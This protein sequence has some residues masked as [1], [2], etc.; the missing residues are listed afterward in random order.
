LATPPTLAYDGERVKLLDQSKLPG[1]VRFV[2]ITT[3][4]S[5]AHAIKT[6]QV[7]GAPAIGAA[8]AFGMVL[9]AKAAKASTTTQLLASLAQAKALLASTRPTAVN[10]FWALDEMLKQV[11]ES[12]SVR[13][14]LLRL[15]ARAVMLLQEDIEIN[16]RLGRNGAALFEEPAVIYT[17]CNAGALATCGYG[18][19]LGVV[20]AL[21]EQGKLVRVY[22]DETRP[23]LQGARLTA[24]ELLQDGIPCT[25]VCDTMAAHVMATR[26]V[27][28]VVVGADRIAANGD[29]ANKIGTYQ[30]ALV[31]QAHQVPF[32]VAAPLST[33]DLSLPEGRAIP[34]EERSPEEVT[35]FAGVQTAPADVEV[36]NPAFD[37]TPAALITGLITEAGVVLKPDTEKVAALFEAKGGK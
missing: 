29:V 37:V 32:Y 18:T 30:L 14:N 6:L 31:A 2:E 27:T 17:H 1:E 26:E 4:E 34:I 5:M 20:R 9:A 12:A 10:L 3:V 22:A 33:F 24:W 36:F 19:A 35:H 21:H 8:A 16:K 11:D 7:R 28:A 25:L 13:E 15:E 23:V